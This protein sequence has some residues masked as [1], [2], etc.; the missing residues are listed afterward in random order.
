VLLGAASLDFN[1]LFLEIL[2]QGKTVEVG[3]A[4]FETETTRFTILDA[5]VSEF[6]FHNNALFMSFLG[7]TYVTQQNLHYCKIDNFPVAY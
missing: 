6:S 7:Q 2:L 4:H 1:Y 3:R 5:P